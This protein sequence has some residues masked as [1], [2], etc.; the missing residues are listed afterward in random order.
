M[1]VY[2]SG[3]SAAIAYGGAMVRS[4]FPLAAAKIWRRVW[5]I[6]VAHMILFI[7]FTAEIA[8]VS[9]KFDNAMFAE[10]MNV[11]TFLDNPYVTLI[12]AILLKFRPVNMDVLPLY[13]V[14]L[15]A[16]PP[17]LWA[18]MRWPVPVLIASIA[19]Y[20][21]A[22]HF[23]WNLP[24]Y[25]GDGGWYFNPFTWQ[26]LFVLGALATRA[27]EVMGWLQRQ[28]RW[29]VPLSI[30][31]VL[32]G[33]YVA[34]SWNVPMLERIVPHWIA[35]VLY[36]VDK[37]SLDPLRLV[38]FLALAYLANHWIAPDAK[39]L[40]S[41]LAR[42]L[43]VCGQNSLSVF[44]VGIFLSFTGDFI[45]LEL[46]GTFT[47]QVAVGVGGIT[48]LCLLAMMIGWYKAAEKAEAAA[49]RQPRLAAAE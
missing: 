24:N 37:T 47:T 2:G 16:F 35:A 5:Q 42:P 12:Q 21:S 27:E 29:L 41:W 25:P 14:L 36:P 4:G 26:L 9:N 43:V 40:E 11:L 6:Y 48:L 10:E 20:F 28:A 1:F 33:L 46:D 8:F 32:F 13:I 31:Y 17:V 15:A 38:H 7:A 30:V 3:Y 49:R 44:C 34:L 39:F 45:L 23:G 22:R 18:A 19:L